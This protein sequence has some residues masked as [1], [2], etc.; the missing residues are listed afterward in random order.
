MRPT[1]LVICV[2]AISSQS[3]SCV[4]CLDLFGAAANLSLHSHMIECLSRHPLP[5][6]SRLTTNK[7]VSL[8]SPLCSP[9]AYRIN[10]RPRSSSSSPLTTFLFMCANFRPTRYDPGLR[11]ILARPQ[12]LFPSGWRLRNHSSS[13]NVGNFRI[14]ARTLNIATT[15]GREIDIGHLMARGHVARDP[16]IITPN[17]HAPDPLPSIYPLSCK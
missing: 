4:S 11:A 17:P 9:S 13:S 15:R 14:R 5:L 16:H 2:T 12:V 6:K 1:T 3:P 8:S 10:H 7:S